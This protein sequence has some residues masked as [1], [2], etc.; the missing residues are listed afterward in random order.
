LTPDTRLR[1]QLPK[2]KLLSPLPLRPLLLLLLSRSTM[3]AAEAPTVAVAVVVAVVAVVVD[4]QCRL[5]P[6]VHLQESSGLHSQAPATDILLEMAQP[7]PRPPT[8]ASVSVGCKMDTARHHITARCPMNCIRLGVSLVSAQ[9]RCREVLPTPLAPSA[10]PASR[11]Q[12]LLLLLTMAAVQPPPAAVLVVV[13]VVLMFVAVLVAA[14]FL[15]ATSAKALVL[16]ALL[17]SM[18]VADGMAPTKTT[19][20]FLFRLV[21]RSLVSRLLSD[22]HSRRCQDQA[23]LQ[24][25]QHHSHNHNHNGH[26][27]RRRLNFDP[28]RARLRFHQNRRQCRLRHHHRRHTQHHVRPVSLIH[29]IQ[30]KRKIRKIRKIHI[31]FECQRVLCFD[32]RMVPSVTFNSTFHFHSMSS[33]WGLRVKGAEGHRHLRGE[34]RCATAC[35][36]ATE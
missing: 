35:Y 24:L 1:R 5:A 29:P 27:N 23:A 34:P 32:H 19:T 10:L 33:I 20:L 3:A 4:Q 25:G 14:Q 11:Q 16:V 36:R 9:A 7:T 30:A 2:P 15:M 8:T 13:V 21:T 28:V 6:H 17:M 18:S 31:I 12:Q 26:H 22:R